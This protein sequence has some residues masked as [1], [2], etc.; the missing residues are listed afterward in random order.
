MFPVAQVGP[1]A[2]QMPGLI[3][4]GG[5]WLGLYLSE[6]ALPKQRAAITAAQIS[7]IV[8][9]VLLAGLLGARLGYVLKFPSA[10][11]Q[12]PLSLVSLNI[13]LLDAWIGLF[14]GS[15]A[16]VVYS[17]RHRLALYPTLDALTPLL[18][19]FSVAWHLSQL[20]SGAGYGL[21]SDLPWAINLLGASRHPTQIYDALASLAILAVIWGRQNQFGPTPG[22]TF[23]VFVVLNAG[24]R[25]FLDAFDA[26]GPVLATGWR[27]SQVAAWTILLAGLVF[28]RRLKFQGE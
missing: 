1:F 11:A 25:L 22:Q 13:D 27:V 7:N 19:A 20:A 23:F 26:A 28:L 18:A 21:P 2:V 5:L 3:L 12:N 14:V 4:L 24:A 10:F 6:Q 9:T 15:V 16:A 17:Q 8:F